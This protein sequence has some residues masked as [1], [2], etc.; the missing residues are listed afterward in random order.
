MNQQF[1]LQNDL[2]LLQHPFYQAWMEGRLSGNALKDYAQQYYH[3]VE[4]FPRYL[5]NALEL[6]VSDSC[7]NILSENLA[8]EDGSRHGVSHPELW[9]R[10]AEGIGTGRD[11]VKSTTHRSAIRKVVDTFTAFS[12]SSL[13]QALGSLYAYESQVPEIADSK[14]EGLKRHFNVQDPRTLAFFEVHKEADVQHRE[15]VKGLIE[16]LSV[17]ERAEAKN[18]ANLACRV[19]WDFLSDVYEANGCQYV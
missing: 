19:L 10:F 9:L 5:S 8:E 18:A 16:G 6:K 13:P 2:F 3:H 7:R 12:Q 4:A 11:E 1:T 15:S 14:I 17:E